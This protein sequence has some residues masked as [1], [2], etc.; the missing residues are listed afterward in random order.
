MNPVRQFA[1]FMPP[2]L[3][4]IIMVTLDVIIVV[5][6]D[7]IIMVTVAVMVVKMTVVYGGLDLE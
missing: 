4:V 1:H 3:H 7:V 6:L 5:S 2:C